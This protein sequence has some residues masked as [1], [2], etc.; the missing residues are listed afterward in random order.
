MSK[1][2][3]DSDYAGGEQLRKIDRALQNMGVSR[4][5]AFM[6][7]AHALE[8]KRREFIAN[9]QGDKE[10]AKAERERARANSPGR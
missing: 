10:R 8:H 3:A 2:G 9:M 1:I 7:G 6:R 5:S 4:D